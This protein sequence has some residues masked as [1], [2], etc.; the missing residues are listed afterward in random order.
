MTHTMADL[1]HFPPP[2]LSDADKAYRAYLDAY[3]IPYDQQSGV[4]FHEDRMESKH[5]P[6]GLTQPTKEGKNK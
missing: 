4:V 2:E 1:L 6:T 3:G 5:H